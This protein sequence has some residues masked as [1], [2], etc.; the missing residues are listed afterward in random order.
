[1]HAALI[2]VLWRCGNPAAIYEDID[3]AN[4]IREAFIGGEAWYCA[5]CGAVLAENQY[6]EGETGTSAHA[7]VKRIGAFEAA[8]LGILIG[9]YIPCGCP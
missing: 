4:Q 9:E 2:C 6:P 3:M 1:V 7:L 8:K 5:D